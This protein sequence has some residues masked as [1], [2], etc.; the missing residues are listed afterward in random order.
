MLYLDRI[1]QNLRIKMAT[2]KDLRRAFQQLDSDVFSA[3]AMKGLGEKGKDLLYKRVKDGFGVN[4]DTEKFPSKKKLKP[5]S[6]RYIEQRRRKGVSGKFGSPSK[7]NLTNTGQM[8]ESIK[9]SADIGEFELS[10]KS[11]SRKGGGSNADVSK[12][13]SRDRPWLSLTKEEQQSLSEEVEKT[14]ASL[15]RRFF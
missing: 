8:L 15:F 2:F 7:S 14:I 11:D 4:S 10:V 1:I 5:L 12:H 3:R 9:V 6:P 13:V